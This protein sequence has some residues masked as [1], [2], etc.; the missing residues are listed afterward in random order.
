MSVTA[1]IVGVELRA[2]TDSY[3]RN[4]RN[5]ESQFN[6]RIGNIESRARQME[7]RFSAFGRSIGRSLAAGFAASVTFRG[8]EGLL[9][10]ATKID[11]SLR[12]AGLSGQAL[13]SVY[14]A[15]Y[16]S[17][18]KNAAP[19]ETLVELYGKAALVQRELGVSS[20]DL[21]RFTD[22][23][24]LA[25]RVAGRDAQ[26]ASGALLQLSQALGSGVVRAEE[27]NSI[28]EGAPTIA[29]AAAA[30]LEE[31]GG[32][33]AKL[34]K[35]VI[36]GKV[37]S[38]AFFRAFEAGA[39]ILQEKAANAV[40][41]IDQRLNNLQ[42]ALIDAA[43]RF[44]TSS[45]A[46]N[47]FGEAIDN[48]T[49]FVNGI[50][51]ES[52]ISEIVAVIDAFQEGARAAVGFARSVGEITGLD[53]VGE[54]ITGG[55]AQRS[56]LGGALTITS[57]TA[58]QRRIDQAFE[59]QIQTAGRL[60]EEAIRN[61]VLGGGAGTATRGTATSTRS[62]FVP[63]TVSLGDFDPPSGGKSKRKRESAFV[64]ETRQIEERTA[65][66]LAET[67][68]QKGLNPLIDDYGFA[69]EKA[70]ATQDLL[71]AAKREG[72]KI[73]PDLKE[74]IE[75]LATAYAQASANAE[76]A[77]ESQKKIQEAAQEISDAAKDVFSGFIQ[78]IRDGV[79]AADAL[80]NAL[81]R[82][83]DRLLDISLDALFDVGGGG[84]GFLGRLFGGFRAS[85]GPVQSGRAYVVGERGPELFAPGQSGRIIPRIPQ[86][87]GTAN[88]S[89][90]ISMPI[91]INAQ[92]ADA[93]GLA[94]VERQLESLKR[95]IPTRIDARAD[96]RQSRGTR[97]AT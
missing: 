70:S 54:F 47:T 34:R 7:T 17:A 45:G 64:R 88:S 57:S 31:A 87:A 69:V 1:D 66:L 75:K 11:N 21:I 41:T 3:L 94:R 68:A 5:A 62:G 33:V 26:S 12:I 2:R 50:D 59:Q 71:N 96:T 78:D 79:S 28:L 97:P 40:L 67:E 16:I 77:A 91:V 51:F 80:E 89:Q 65:A 8:I 38:E 13:E 25:L 76:R 20:E 14:N 60:T 92:G 35:L 85:G 23:V 55:S 49:G 83:L 46:A 72:L 6:A 19:F 42:T 18:Q 61:S 90:T 73:T 24:A 81:N 84:G 22:N 48:V 39:P 27:F 10:S 95:S 58:L 74:K 29:Q 63:T 32:S 37:S 9:D 44:N 53:K 52:L 43:R 56:F 36:D 4:L 30:G 86:V 82:V 93:A 15:L